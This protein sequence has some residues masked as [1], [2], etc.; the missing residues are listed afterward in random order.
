DLAIFEHRRVPGPPQQDRLHRR[1]GI[2]LACTNRRK[3]SPS[4]TD[5]ATPQVR[6]RQQSREDPVQTPAVPPPQVPSPVVAL[7]GATGF[8]GQ[9]LLR[10]L[11][12]R[13][14]RIRVLLRRPTELPVECASALIGDLLNPRNMAAA[15]AGI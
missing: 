7:T 2:C 8:I 3:D 11:P 13:G 10:Q 6:F 4:L 15:L 12:A 14:Y 9:Y 5:R 1:L